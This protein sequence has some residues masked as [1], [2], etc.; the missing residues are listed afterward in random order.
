MNVCRRK[1]FL[2]VTQVLVVCAFTTGCGMDKIFAGQDKNAESADPMVGELAIDGSGESLPGREW[3]QG[4]TEQARGF[5]AQ[6]KLLNPTTF[7]TEGWGFRKLD[8]TGPNRYTTY[9]LATVLAKGAENVKKYFPSGDRLLVGSL[10]RVRGGPSGGHSSHQNGLDADIA[11]FSSD[12]RTTSVG[13]PDEFTNMVIGGKLSSKF[14]FQRNYALLQG[15]FGSGRVS[16]IFVHSAVKNGFCRYLKSIG[17]DVQ[18][19][20]M[21]RRLMVYPGHHHHFHVRISCPTRSPTCIN[22]GAPPLETGC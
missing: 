17:Q 19:N 8:P 11:Y 13:E 1:L 4:S 7:P 9:D 21:L 20:E 2:L 18:N 16:R 22:Q 14:D 15:L 3:T 10:S 5:Y 12:R 6:G